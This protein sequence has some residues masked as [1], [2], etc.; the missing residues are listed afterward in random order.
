M[1]LSP[2]DPFAFSAY[3]GTGLV[4]LRHEVRR[5]RVMFVRAQQGH[6]AAFLTRATLRRRRMVAIESGM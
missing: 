1:R 5:R 3:F 2:L 4:L 6:R